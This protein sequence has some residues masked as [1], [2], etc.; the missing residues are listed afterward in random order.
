MDA[1]LT[2]RV[3]K[4]RATQANMEEKLCLMV[5]VASGNDG[6]YTMCG[7]SLGGPSKSERLQLD[8]AF[9]THSTPLTQM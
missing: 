8:G 6:T 5:S 3:T 4:M 2:E 1:R 9:L 7:V